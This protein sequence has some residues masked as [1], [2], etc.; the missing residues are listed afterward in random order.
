M[1]RSTT[2]PDVSGITLFQ[3]MFAA[4]LIGFRRDGALLHAVTA[5]E[6][7]A[8]WKS[9]LLLDAPC[10]ATGLKVLR[11]RDETLLYEWPPS[12][13]NLPAKYRRCDACHEAT[14]RKRP[15]TRWEPKEATK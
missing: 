5:K 2:V 8:K 1:R 9:D 15:R 11:V 14:G 4:P 13:R 6:L 3:A 7:C 10:G 12:T